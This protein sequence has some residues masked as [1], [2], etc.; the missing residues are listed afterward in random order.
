MP[1][2][3]AD[4]PPLLSEGF[5]PSSCSAIPVLINSISAL[6]D[7]LCSLNVGEL[8]FRVAVTTDPNDFLPLFG[9][10]ASDNLLVVDS[11]GAL[12]YSDDTGATW[13]LVAAGYCI[14]N[15][16]LANILALQGGAGLSPGCFYRV[17]DNVHAEGGD[18]LMIALETD[19]LSPTGWYFHNGGGIWFP[20]EWNPD[21][22][23]ILYLKDPRWNNVAYG[24]LAVDE[25]IWTVND[26]LADVAG[27]WSDNTFVNTLSLDFSGI[28]ASEYGVFKNNRIEYSS[29]ELGGVLTTISNNVIT[30][31]STFEATGLS[32]TCT[33]ENNNARGAS[34]TLQTCESLTFSGNIVEEGAFTI[35]TLTDTGGIN[36]ITNNKV[37]GAAGNSFIQF[38]TC[39]HLTIT[40][41]N[42]SFS[43]ID[44]TTVDDT[45][46]STNVLTNGAGV[47]G[48]G[49]D[50]I[51]FSDNVI[52]N[53]LL[54]FQTLT[55]VSILRNVVEHADDLFWD[56]VDNSD[57]L[58]NSIGFVAVVGF[59]DMST[60]S[61]NSNNFD[62]SGNIS[63]RNV[64][65]S[66]FMNN[67]FDGLSTAT[68]GT[69]I[70][71][72]DSITVSSNKINSGSSLTITDA[73]DLV[74]NENEAK[75]SSSYNITAAGAG[76]ISNNFA[77]GSSSY[78]VNN[79]GFT[80]DVFN[81]EISL[82][83]F[84]RF[85]VHTGTAQYNRLVSA[86]VTATKT[87]PFT[88]NVNKWFDF[89]VVLAAGANTNNTRTND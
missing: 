31:N 51:I 40:N 38:N 36:N 35:V 54:N 1:F 12:W 75:N 67:S 62:H 59:Q 37:Y 14:T 50:T 7:Y 47:T 3:C 29:L 63:F 79:A 44:L 78:V 85:G 41:N 17:N 74:V 83:S 65:N 61:I 26:T 77:N 8:E 69:A 80:G 53:S 86:D 4:S 20:M 52:N 48:S 56:T 9:G 10:T 87:S 15:D 68:I 72:N 34:V 42:V 16:T 27:N 19:R 89:T 58:E 43:S 66:N 18:L 45:S 23:D 21:N 60:N 49:S 57:F 46:M 39:D 5:P 70:T 64:D 22:G 2:N 84:M 73:T 33:L 88:C 30:Q 32:G 11:D 25:F 71:A 6:S 13:T 82:N 24:V 81:N 28:T 55:G 76:E